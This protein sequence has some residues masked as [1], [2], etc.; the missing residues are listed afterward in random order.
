MKET[1][2]AI[3]LIIW[4]GG[5][6]WVIYSSYS[7]YKRNKRIAELEEERDFFASIIGQEE[8]FEEVV[9]ELEILYGCKKFMS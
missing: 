9:D 3:I 4:M 2:L 5:F 7:N 8:R 1:V 6:L